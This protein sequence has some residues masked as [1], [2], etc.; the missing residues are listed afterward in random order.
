MLINAPG[1][2]R[3]QADRQLVV[4]TLVLIFG[5]VCALDA[6]TEL[7]IQHIAMD[8]FA[9]EQGLSLGCRC[10]CEAFIA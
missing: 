9:D 5:N 1:S 8:M 6:P 10:G 4:T 2:R 3:R 7:I